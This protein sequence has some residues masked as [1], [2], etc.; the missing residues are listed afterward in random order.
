MLN[1]PPPPSV[2]PVLWEYFDRRQNFP[3]D[4]RCKK[5]LIFFLTS[6]L[7]KYFPHELEELGFEVADLIIRYHGQSGLQCSLDKTHVM[8]SN[9]ETILKNFKLSVSAVKKIIIEDMLK[10]LNE[11][12]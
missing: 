1:P 12:E 7:A 4:L 8:L 3:G 6:L 2:E 5:S 10:L 9:L 11:L